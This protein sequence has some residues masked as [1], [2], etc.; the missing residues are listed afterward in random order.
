M[1]RT[2]N[3]DIDVVI[4]EDYKLKDLI[5]DGKYTKA[6]HFLLP[7]L[8][9]KGNMSIFTRYFANAF[10]NDEEIA[11]VVRNPLF[12]LFKTKSFDDNWRNFEFGVKTSPR[13]IWVYDVGK[14]D[15][16]YLIMFLF[17]FPSA[18]RSDYN[19]FLEG[20][21]SKFS[22][23]YKKLFPETTINDYGETI[24]NPLYGVVHKTPTF[25][26]SLEMVVGETIKPSYEY[27]EK[28]SADR[29]VFRKKEENEKI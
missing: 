5:L 13:C 2:D 20:D 12:V 25:K 23:Y 15:D 17:E 24:E 22:D 28:W 1:R 3:T 7:G 16:D 6:T 18:Y 14:N 10:I 4:H 27:W 29:E 8:H 9:L 11:H 21:Y 26:K 19:Q